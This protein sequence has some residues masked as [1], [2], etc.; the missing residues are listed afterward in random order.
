VGEVELV[1]GGAHGGE[2]VEGL[3]QHLV[4][5][6]VS[7]VDLVQHHDGAQAELQ[8]LAEHELGLGHDP[9]LGVDEQQAAVHHAEDPLHLAAEVGVAGSV[10][11]VDARLASLAVP[12]HRGA[13]GQD[14][15]AAFALL[16][17]GVHGAF[18]RRLVGAEHTRLGEELVDQR[19][20][21]VVDVG[22][23]GDVSE[24]HLAQG[25]RIGGGG[26]PRGERASEF[27]KSGATYPRNGDSATPRRCGG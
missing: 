10:D 14:G 17:V 11:D 4:R 23:D 6:G 3:V 16:V 7:A 5:I 27:G 20:L 2:Q 24:V 21:A 8:R 9:F 1:V 18:D 13:L 15:D 26:G 25:E 22:D 12:E 19:S